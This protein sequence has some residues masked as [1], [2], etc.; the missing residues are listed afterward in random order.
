MGREPG[1]DL[2]DPHAR[3][4]KDPA[5]RR[6]VA[7]D[8]GPRSEERFFP[9]DRP[10]V[11]RGVDPHF[12][13]V[14]HDH[15]ELPEARVD[16]DPAPDDLDGRLVEP[17][18][19]D[20]RARAE[21]APFPEDAIANVVLVRNVRLRH[22]DGV[23]H[24]ARIT[25]LRARADR[26]RRPDVAVRADLRVRAD[27]RRP[28][29]VRAPPHAGALLD[30][31]LAD[32]RRPRVDVREALPLQRSE[33]RRVRTQEVPRSTHVDPFPGEPEPI[34]VAFLRERANRVRDLVLPPRRFRRL[35]DERENVLIEDV[36]ARVDQVRFGPARLF[37][38]GRDLAVLRLD[39]AK[40]FRVRDFGKRQNG[41][42]DFGVMGHQRRERG[43]GYNDVAVHA[44]E[45]AVDVR[46]HAT[47]R[48]RRPEALGLLLVRD[49]ETERLPGPDAF[50][51]PMPLPSDEHR[52][53][54]DVGAAERLE[55][56]AEEWLAGDGQ[57][58]LG[59]IGRGGAPSEAL[60]GRENHGLHS[61]APFA[62][63]RTVEYISFALAVS[64][65]SVMTRIFG[66]V[67]E[68]R[69]SDQPSLNW[70]R[71]PS[72]VVTSAPIDRSFASSRDSIAARRDGSNGID[73]RI[74]GYRGTS[75]TI[76]SSGRTAT[77][78]TRPA[79]A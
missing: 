18:V 76:A 12:H 75:A 56:V 69:T 78:A 72:T 33:Q 49:R 15:P 39:D 77:I 37:F 4:S 27:N 5:A 63:D 29:D 24:F 70:S 35:V 40:R 43:R 60:T 22:E 46:P 1:R 10:R 47:D 58:G 71:H 67:P 7:A 57:K 9:N 44:Q 62:L 65:D 26:G 55:R 51:D 6:D 20:L 66:S 38:E 61:A 54:R 25:H 30:A 45:I 73:P 52:D 32:E 14:S 53:P 2:G 16:I 64:R 19:R 74:T 11:D 59:E 68:N 28:F 79:A 34:D 23:L 48:V 13:I 21:V 8:A 17:Q 50:P 36:D 41:T 31:D 42:V 3:T